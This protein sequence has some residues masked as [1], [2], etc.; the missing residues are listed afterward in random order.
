MLFETELTVTK[1]RMHEFF[2]LCFPGFQA[3]IE[4]LDYLKFI[5]LF[6]SNIAVNGIPELRKFLFQTFVNERFKVKRSIC[7]IFQKFIQYRRSRFAEG[8][9]NNVSQLDIGK[10]ETVLKLECQI[11]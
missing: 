9:R 4:S 1:L 7:G 5:G 3:F 8:V 2:K 6:R 10:R 11:R